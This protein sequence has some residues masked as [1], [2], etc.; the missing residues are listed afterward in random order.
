MLR[1][2]VEAALV[3]G[4]AIAYLRK[5]GRDAHVRWVYAAL[6][7]AIVSSLALGYG[8]SKFQWNQEKFEGWVMLAAAALVATVVVW[9]V[10]AGKRMKQQIESGLARAAGAPSSAVAV[11]LFV[12]LMV[13]REGVETVLMLGAISISSEGFAVVAGTVVGLGLAVVFG[14]LFV[15]GSLRINLGRFFR[16]TT[17]ILLFVV[18]QLVVSGLHELSEQGVLPSS[19]AEMAIIGPIVRNEVFFLVAMLALASM[20]VLLDWKARPA[21]AGGEASAADRRKAAWLARRE[22]LWMTS[23]CAAAGVFIV[24][25]TA[26][27][28]YAKT[29]TALSPARAVEAPDGVLRIPL[30]E[31]EDGRL[32]RYRLGK[33]RFLLIRRA[34]REPGVALDACE[35]CGDAGYYERGLNVFCRNCAAA[36]FI[37]S[38]GITGGCNPVPLKHRVEDGHVVIEAPS[39]AA[40]EKLFGE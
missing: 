1:E 34:G 9:M 30:S 16:V 27:F 4:I 10:R 23:V 5:T 6:A 22:R 33:V 20:M 37:P 3:I 8:F 2:G 38:I 21:R 15:R 35:I 14:V 39:L 7:I 24:L 17:V 12:F 19:K 29:Q 31:L 18:G 32:H 25:V 36:I 28:I 26:E 11:F 40:Y 13:L